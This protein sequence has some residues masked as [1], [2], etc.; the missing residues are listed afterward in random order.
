MQRKY[1]TFFLLWGALI[2][3]IIC[4]GQ[5]ITKTQLRDSLQK[6][7]SF[8][9]FEDNFFI[10]GLPTNSEI[11]RNTADAKFQVSF[12]Q[13]VTRDLLPFETYLFFT[14]TQKAFWN[15]FEESFPFRDINFNPSLA[16]GKA[17][18]SKDDHLKGIAV[19]GFEHESNGRDSIS[20]RSWNRLN[21]SYTTRLFKNTTARFEVWAPFGLGEFNEDL[22]D[23]VGL[24]EIH[25][26]HERIN[27][28]LTFNLML[29]KGLGFDGKGAVRSR[30]YYNPFKGNK[31]N[32]YI[33]LEWYVGQGESLLDYQKSSSI[34]R[35][36]YVIKSSEFDWFK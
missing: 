10:S 11:D 26:N 25:I 36:G 31:L 20:S 33:M 1:L 23:F 17:I 14:Y 7:P 35:L 30:V 19:L 29:R 22:I 21:A 27:D 13:M 24:G 28:K 2:S 8:S 4:Q 6:L 34:I 18:Y 9:S 15:I 32:Q 12:K 5:V 3:T 16:L